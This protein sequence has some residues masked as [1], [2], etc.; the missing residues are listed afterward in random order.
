MPTIR[1]IYLRTASSDASVRKHA[2]RAHTCPCGK[3]C[4]GNGGWSSHKRACPVYQAARAASSRP[5]E[6]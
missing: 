2:T 6:E 5:V 1:G 3:R 4:L